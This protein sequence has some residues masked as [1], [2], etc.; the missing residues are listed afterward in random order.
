MS[1]LDPCHLHFEMRS[2][3]TALETETRLHLDFQSRDDS[4]TPMYTRLSYKDLRLFTGIAQK[5]KTSVSSRQKIAFTSEPT[6]LSCENLRGEVVDRLKSMGFDT[7]SC[8]LALL[9]CD[10][11]FES[12]A[13]WLVRNQAVGR[14]HRSIQPSHVGPALA[15]GHAAPFEVLRAA[16]SGSSHLVQRERILQSLNE[17]MKVT[18]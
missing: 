10:G 2:E 11:M 15:S 7:E 8:L 4:F 14:K 6:Q 12:A 16:A 9:H 17:H 1:I 18:A 13:I 3:D 5:L